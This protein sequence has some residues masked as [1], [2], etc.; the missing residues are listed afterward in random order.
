MTPMSEEAKLML[1]GLIVAVVVAGSAYT[2]TKLLAA[3]ADHEKAAV[4]NA[5]AQ[6]QHSADIQTAAWQGRAAT[7]EQNLGAEHASIDNLRAGLAA[8]VRVPVSAPAARLPA[9]PAAPV[10]GAAPAAAVIHSSVVCETPDLLRSEY[11]EALRADTVAADERVLY[12][13]WPSVSPPR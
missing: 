1:L 13:A 4:A 5:T 3:G 11:G 7:A 8:L 10:S 9:S 6:A 12:A 2:V